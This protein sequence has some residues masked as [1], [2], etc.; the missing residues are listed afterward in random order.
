MTTPLTF[1]QGWGRDLSHGL[2]LDEEL[3]V[4]RWLLREEFLLSRDGPPERLSNPKQS[5]LAL[6]ASEQQ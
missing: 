4:I 1:Q 2:T 5:S 3:E 6:H